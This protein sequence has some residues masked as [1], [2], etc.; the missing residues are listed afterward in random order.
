MHRTV[1][2]NVDFQSKETKTTQ[3]F[4]K[5]LEASA[6]VSGGGW[7]ASVSASGSYRDAV[8]EMKDEAA[9]YVLFRGPVYVLYIKNQPRSTTSAS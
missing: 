6:S 9:I 1:H 7:G 5:Q 3:E 8:E 4:E 2:C